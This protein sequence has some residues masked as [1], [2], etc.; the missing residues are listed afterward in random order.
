MRWTQTHELHDLDFVDNFALV[1]DV[2]GQL[3]V[4]LT[5]DLDMLSKQ[6]YRLMWTTC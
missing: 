1:S 2:L 4:K 5:I 6:G 3:Q